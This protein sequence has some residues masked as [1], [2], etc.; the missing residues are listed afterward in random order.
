MPLRR[1]NPQRWPWRAS[2]LVDLVHRA[3][4][5]RM[6]E[7]RLVLVDR[8]ERDLAGVVGD[9]ELLTAAQRKRCARAAS[10]WFTSEE[11]D[12]VGAW[13]V[14]RR[15]AALVRFPVDLPVDPDVV[16]DPAGEPVGATGL[17]PLWEDASWDLPFHVVGRFRVDPAR[18]SRDFDPSAWRQFRGSVD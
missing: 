8:P 10:G 6:V 14:A 13:L 16:E 7:L 11:C 15:A 5:Y 4:L 12:A 2:T 1:T 17:L 18:G 9:P 3:R